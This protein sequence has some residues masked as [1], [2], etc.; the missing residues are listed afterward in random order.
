MQNYEQ[1]AKLVHTLGILRF[2]SSLLGCAFV[3]SGVALGLLA[4]LWFI[5]VHLE[6]QQ[7]PLEGIFFFFTLSALFISSGILLR[8]FSYNLKN[9]LSSGNP[10]F[11]L[12]YFESQ[13][14]FLW[15]AFFFIFF[16]FSVTALYLFHIAL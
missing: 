6:N 10:S 12:Q 8:N 3:G 9:Y 5:G 15:N 13:K 4:A 1:N 7:I 2:W 14:H 16:F 11:L